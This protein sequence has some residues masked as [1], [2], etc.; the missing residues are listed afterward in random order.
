ML[1]CT[2]DVQRMYNGRTAKQQGQKVSQDTIDFIDIE[3]A[4][5]AIFSHIADLN[6]EGELRRYLLD[7]SALSSQDWCGVHRTLDRRTGKRKKSG[8]TSGL[9]YITTWYIVI[10]IFWKTICK[11]LLHFVECLGG[12]SVSFNVTRFGS[13]KQE[14]VAMIWATGRLKMCCK[15][16][17][18]NMV[19]IFRSLITALSEQKGCQ[20]ANDKET[21]ATQKANAGPA[22]TPAQMKGATNNRYKSWAFTN[23]SSNACNLRVWSKSGHK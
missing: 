2:A 12:Y 20:R 19:I 4:C 22:N 16:N 10:C 17:S 23:F 8:A 9:S 1:G 18:I 11:I 6:C 7:I 14:N 5:V 3:Y 15:M 21:E 13:K